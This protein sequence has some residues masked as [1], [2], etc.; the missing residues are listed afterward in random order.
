MNEGSGVVVGHVA[1][2]AAAVIQSV[3]ECALST[4]GRSVGRSTLREFT[5]DPE[6]E[7]APG[8]PK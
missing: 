1:A 4:R 8:R 6:W 2:A 5:C 7:V 3:I